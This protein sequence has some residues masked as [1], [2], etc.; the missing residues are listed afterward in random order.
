MCLP[1][2]KQKYLLLRVLNSSSGPITLSEA[3]HAMSEVAKV[4]YGSNLVAET[5]KSPATLFNGLAFQKFIK[6]ASPHTW[7]ITKHGRDQISFIE[8]EFLAPERV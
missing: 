2:T 8:R 1:D 5:P 3:W 6:K 4:E 7:T